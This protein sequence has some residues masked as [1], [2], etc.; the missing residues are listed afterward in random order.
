MKF[1]NLEEWL[2]FAVEKTIIYNEAYKKNHYNEYFESDIFKGL[3]LNSKDCI[4]YIDVMALKNC[5]TLNRLSNKFKNELTKIINEFELYEF[6]EYTPKHFYIIQVA[7]TINLFLHHQYFILRLPFGADKEK[8]NARIITI[9]KKA[10]KHNTKTILPS[11]SPKDYL[12]YFKIK[13]QEILFENYNFIHFTKNKREKI[14]LRNELAD[15]FINAIVSDNYLI[16]KQYHSLIRITEN[17]KKMY[18][19]EYQ[20]LMSPYNRENI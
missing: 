12:N 7:I 18:K 8:Y 20:K 14:K 2:D 5:D 15:E 16:D 6:N 11:L 9:T 1:N 3:N 4:Q 10:T 17:S 13:C 19:E